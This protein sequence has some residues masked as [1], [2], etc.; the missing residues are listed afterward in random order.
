MM[1]SLDFN[2]TQM[3]I[4]IHPTCT[5][6]DT[7]TVIRLA[8]FHCFRRSC[9][10][11]NQCCKICLGPRKKKAEKLANTFNTGLVTLK[12][13]QDPEETNS[14]HAEDMFI[15]AET[16]MNMAGAEMF[17]ASVEWSQKVESISNSYATIPLPSRANHSINSQP[18]LNSDT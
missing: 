11:S 14:E 3:S 6:Q 1:W 9:L 8:C 15:S 12:D 16:G 4:V 5:Q 7:D 13:Q 18:T 2:H 10:P 17:Y